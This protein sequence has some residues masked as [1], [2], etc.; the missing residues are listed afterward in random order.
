MEQKAAALFEGANLVYV[1]TLMKDGSPQ[2][3]PVW[4]NFEDGHILVNT[5]EGR[6]KHKN[7]QRDPRVAI[8]LVAH[9]NPLCMTSI[10]GVVVRTIPDYNYIHADKLAKKYMNLDRYPFRRK[11]EKRIILKIRPDRVF[12]MPEIKPDGSG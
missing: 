8:S 7:I 2:L 9:D 5:A 12:V 4:A 10:R 6:I 1:A 11:D 3:T